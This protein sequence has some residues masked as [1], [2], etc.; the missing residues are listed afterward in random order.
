MNKPKARGTAAETAVT[1]WLAANGFPNAERRALR[2][3]LDAGDISGCPGLCVEVKGGDAARTAGHGLIIQW[4]AETETERRNAGAQV[5]VLVVQRKGFGPDRAGMWW[6]L[7]YAETL[8]RL[9][10]PEG[11]PQ[12]A[13]HAPIRLHLADLVTLLRAAGYGAPL[14]E[15]TAS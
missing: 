2:G 1:R 10:V 11:D 9:W 3:T 4:L 8:C 5:G 12:A 15:E 6:A 13:H 14:I 7:V